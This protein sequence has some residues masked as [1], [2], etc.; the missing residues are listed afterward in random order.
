MGQTSKS[1]LTNICQ[2][3][4]KMGKRLPVADVLRLLLSKNFKAVHGLSFY[5]NKLKKQANE[6]TLAL[7]KAERQKE[8]LYNSFFRANPSVMLLIDPETGDI[9]DANQAAC[10]YYGLAH[11]VLCTNN[12][13]QINVLTPREMFLEMRKAI[14]KK[15][16]HFNF[17]HRLYNGVI[18]DVEVIFHPVQIEN[19]NFLLSIIQDITSKK[20]MID[21]LIEAKNRAEESDRLKYAFLMN[22][23]H[24]IRTP[25]NGIL[26][27]SDLLR[28]PNLSTELQEEYIC[29]IEKSSARLLCVIN[30]IIEISEIEA[31]LVK[32]SVSE[33]NLNEQIEEI[34]NFFK[35][36]A[37]QKK[38]EFSAKK[39]L[40]YSDAV[41][42]TDKAKIEIVLTKLLKNALKFTHSGS[43]E[44]GY[45]K[46]GEFLEFFVK[47]TGVGIQKEHV[48]IIFEKFRQENETLSRHYE[49]AGVGLSIAKA[50]VEL[51]GGKI[52]AESEEN[53]GSTFFFTIP[54]RH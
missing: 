5:R 21:E 17:R 39:T 25:M 13:S 48:Q 31:G 41:V 43:I 2:E 3:P 14:A 28:E 37:D 24:E 45:E 30:D 29:L 7:K 1:K 54:Y 53:I 34:Y 51:L 27:F 15:Q 33:T 12:I 9:K 20:R 44:F 35:S 42:K 23:S 52:W 18:K 10:C 49:G 47:D 40:K 26:G 46:K 11:Q 8:S 38:I 6:L 32:I 4:E 50:Y 22:M 16:S 19:S 36:E